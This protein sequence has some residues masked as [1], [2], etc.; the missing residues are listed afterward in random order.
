MLKKCEEELLADMQAQLVRGHAAMKRQTC[1]A[2]ESADA[3]LKSGLARAEGDRQHFVASLAQSMNEV[4][5]LRSK[6]EDY[7]EWEEGAGYA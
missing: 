6:Y 5:A 1:E 3:G 4:T 7:D 2:V